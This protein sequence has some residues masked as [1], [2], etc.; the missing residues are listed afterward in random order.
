MLLTNLDKISK[1]I[2]HK[3]GHYPTKETL[4]EQSNNSITKLRL[5]E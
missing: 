1:N 5:G 3:K 4:L 2:K